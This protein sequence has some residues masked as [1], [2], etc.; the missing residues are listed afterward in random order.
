MNRVALIAGASGGI[1]SAVG[2]ALRSKSYNLSLLDINIGA[3]DSGRMLAENCD[4]T[5]PKDVEEVV[6]KTLSKFGR[7]D[8]VVN[9]AGI[10]HLGTVDELTLEDLEKVYD[11]NVKGTFNVSKAVLPIMREQESGYIINLGSLRAIKPASGKAAYCMSKSAVRTFS[12]VLSKEAEKYGIKVTVINP[13]FVDTNIY[14][15]V[16]L[17]PYV[18]SI[19]GRGLKEAPLTGPGDIAK[20]ILYLLDLSPGACIEELNIG[21]LWGFE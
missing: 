6:S 21:R 16:Q 12:K 11:V 19:P 1:G 9:C 20:T 17:R 5:K 7:I 14:G 8:I 10:S 3:T 4:V 2:E 15:E 13:G 18:Q